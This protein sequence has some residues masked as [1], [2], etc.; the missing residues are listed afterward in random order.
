MMLHDEDEDNE[1]RGDD[2]YDN[3]NFEVMTRQYQH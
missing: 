1:D 3:D 2:N